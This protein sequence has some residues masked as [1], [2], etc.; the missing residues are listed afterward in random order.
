MKAK[1]VMH[2]LHGWLKPGDSLKH[3]ARMMKTTRRDESNMGVRSLPVLDA[4][5]KLAGIVTMGDILKSVLPGYLSLG[6]MGDFT[7]DGMMEDMA[8]KVAGKTVGEIMTRDVVTIKENAPLMAAVDHMINH[9]YKRLPVVDEAGKV[10]GVLYE[11]DVFYVITDVC[12][13]IP[14]A[15]APEQGGGEGSAR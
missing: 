4:D 12:C 9:G 2:Q 1:D 5:G 13:E 15:K 10:T 11:R 6:N 7:W 3:A 8:R 14:P